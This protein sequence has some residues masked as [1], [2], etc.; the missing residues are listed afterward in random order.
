MNAA[1]RVAA[2]PELTPC[3]R[4]PGAPLR[5][6]RH[7]RVAHNLA[8]GKTAYEA[9]RWRDD[10]GNWVGA[11]D[12]AGS[13]Y[14]SNAKRLCQRPEIRERVV[15]VALAE[16]EDA[17]IYAGWL[18]NDVKLFARASLAKFWKRKDNGELELR[19]GAPVLDF[20]QATEDDLRTLGKLKWTKFGPEIELRDLPAAA[21]KIG[22]YLGLWKARMEV[23]GKDGIPLQIERIERVIIEAPNSNGTGLPPTT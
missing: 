19:N 16:A 8:A 3:G 2:A 12:P 5:N 21:Q 15:E 11:L 1:A 22:E 18:L 6:R 20:S 17:G 14:G 7:E 10:D 4:V 23:T 13:S 9:C